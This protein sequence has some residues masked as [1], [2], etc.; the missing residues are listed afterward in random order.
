M[1]LLHKHG[2]P[3]CAG[4]A[5]K[6]HEEFVL[7]LQEKFPSIESLDKY[8]NNHTKMKFKCHICNNEWDATANQLL[9]SK[10]CPTCELKARSDKLR[11]SNEQFLKELS[12]IYP[13]V[14]IL[15]EYVSN[16]TKLKW[17]ELFSRSG[18]SESVAMFLA[19]LDLVKNGRIKISDDNQTIALS[20]GQK[21]RNRKEKEDGEVAAGTV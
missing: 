7:E 8:I 10:G 15:E 16:K 1:H 18:R 14:E 2:C 4:L 12:M 3:K 5:R 20:G 6:T 11:K 17:S 9:T 21:H 19:V 13:E